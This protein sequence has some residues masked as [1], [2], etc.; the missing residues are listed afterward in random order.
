MISRLAV[1][2]GLACVL[3]FPA[4]ATDFRKLDPRV[5]PVLAAIDPEGG[6]HDL[7]TYK[8]RV[9][10]I[11]FWASWCPPCRKEMP[12]MQRLM[13][14]LGG[15][16]FVILAVDSGESR[17]ESESFLKEIRPD[18]PILLDP[19]SEAA[20]RWKVF[21]MPTSFLVDK[22]GRVRYALAGATEWDEG[23]GWLLIQ[24]MLAE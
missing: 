18:F 2:L 15:K 6:K 5:A 13:Q 1:L 8:G 10:L 12:S 23:D 24:E 7:A 14:R 21:A 3:A 20:R 16:S 22:Q 4:W 17:A 9:V 19:D 11:N